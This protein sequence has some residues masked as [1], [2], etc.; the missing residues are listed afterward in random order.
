[1][2]RPGIRN[3]RSAFDVIFRCFFWPLLSRSTRYAAVGLISGLVRAP[4]IYL[5]MYPAERA[6][7]GQ[8]VFFILE[9]LDIQYSTSRTM[10][11]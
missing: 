4:A 5:P 8:A 2:R 3:G 6:R 10:L 7:V 11:D 9:G 1:M